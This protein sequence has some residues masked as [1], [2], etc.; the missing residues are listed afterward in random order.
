VEN[1]SFS[2]K[3]PDFRRI[4]PADCLD[5]GD[6]GR[7]GSVPEHLVWGYFCGFRF[8]ILFCFRILFCKT[9]VK[10]VANCKLY[11]KTAL[12]L[13][14]VLFEVF[15]KR[16]PRNFS[17]RRSL[18]ELW[19]RQPVFSDRRISEGIVLWKRM[20]FGTRFSKACGFVSENVEKRN[21]VRILRKKSDIPRRLSA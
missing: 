6:F 1:L 9:G 21:F 17:F 5:S 8:D 4:L 15:P 12:F 20:S 7:L 14:F 3:M 2:G 18:L 13:R 10:T 19:F 11:E 16:F